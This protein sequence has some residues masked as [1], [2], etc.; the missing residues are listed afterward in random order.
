MVFYLSKPTCPML[1]LRP[2]SLT[3]RITCGAHDVAG[4]AWCRRC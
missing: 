3:L 4:A 2:F 1:S